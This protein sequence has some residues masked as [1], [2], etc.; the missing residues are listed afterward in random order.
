MKTVLFA[1]IAVCACFIF[2]EKGRKAGA[3]AR[4]EEIMTDCVQYLTLDET[5]QMC[6]DF[7]EEDGLSP[8]SPLLI[9]KASKYDYIDGYGFIS[10]DL[11]GL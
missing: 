8:D 7:I 2:Y 10:Q 5:I 4:E 9:V 1:L 11:Q 3:K 6:N